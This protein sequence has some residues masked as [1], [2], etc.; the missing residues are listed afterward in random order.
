MDIVDYKYANTTAI[1]VDLSNTAYQ[2]TG[3]GTA[4]FVNIEG[5]SGASGNDVFTNSGLDNYFEGRGGNDTFNLTNHGGHDTLIYKLLD[6]TDATGGNGIDVVNGFFI[7]TFEATAD[8]DRIDING[9][10]NGYTASGS[11]GYAAKYINGVATIN[12]GDDISNY[13]NVYFDGTNTHVQIDKN[14]T[15]NYSDLLVMNNV[16]T[17]LATLLANHQII[18]G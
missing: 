15:G 6:S 13:L 18:I 5:I 4:K 16:H 14:G 7:G 9:L 2:N 1:T 17:D 3:F 11:D 8:A 12:S 10:L